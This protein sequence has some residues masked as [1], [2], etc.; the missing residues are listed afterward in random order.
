MRI[1]LVRHEKTGRAEAG[2]APGAYHDLPLTIE[3]QRS[4][5]ALATYFDDINFTAVYSSDMIRAIETVK[6]ATRDKYEVRI[7]PRFAERSVE[8]VFSEVPCIAIDDIIAQHTQEDEIL[9]V[10]HGRTIKSI[11]CGKGDYKDFSD[12]PT[13]DNG[14]LHILTYNENQWSVERTNY[15]PRK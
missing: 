3:G 8:E 2:V 15:D 9:V 6:R 12:S 11:M 13:L 4:A 14:C 10:S 5:D 1:Y 7:D